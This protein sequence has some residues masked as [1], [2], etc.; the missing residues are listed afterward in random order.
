MLK[1]VTK[2]GQKMVYSTSLLT[3][4]Q[5]VLVGE[6][7]C[8]IKKRFTNNKF[9]DNSTFYKMLVYGYLFL[10]EPGKVK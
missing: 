1:L 3:P 10:Y 9:V 8:V 6:M 4:G 2:N 7:P 5:E